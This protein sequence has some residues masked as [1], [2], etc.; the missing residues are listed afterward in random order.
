MNES[1]TI[2]FRNSNEFYNWLSENYRLEHGIWIKMAKKDSGI[3]SINSDEAVDVGLCW[4]WISSHRKSLDDKY[5]LQKYT[6]RRPKSKWS[7]V[8]VEKVKVL[9][10]LGLIRPPGHKE[11]EDAKSDGRWTA[12]L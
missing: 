1:P 7:K 6:P 10:G 12:H 3:E 8:N 2:Q 4:G 11:I 5:Y 9:E